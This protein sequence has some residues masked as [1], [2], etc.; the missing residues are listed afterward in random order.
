MCDCIFILESMHEVPDDQLPNGT[1]IMHLH[2]KLE[3]N[4]GNLI[5]RNEN[6]ITRHWKSWKI[7]VWQ[8]HYVSHKT[9]AFEILIIDDSI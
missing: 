8:L 7:V 6:E 1:Q 2:N 5:L 4:L 3:W 9:S